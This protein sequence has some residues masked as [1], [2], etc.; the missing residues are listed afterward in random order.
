MQYRIYWTRLRYFNRPGASGEGEPSVYSYQITWSIDGRYIAFTDF[1]Y[2]QASKITDG[3]GL[4][5]FSVA[6]GGGEPEVT[7][8]RSFYCEAISRGIYSCQFHP[9]E[10]ILLFQDSNSTYI[11]TFKDSERAGPTPVHFPDASNSGW[12]SFEVSFTQCG[13]FIAVYHSGKPWP[14]LMPL[15]DV[16]RSGWTSSKP[17]RRLPEVIKILNTAA[18]DEKENMEDGEGDDND[19]DT[20]TTAEVEGQA[21]G[22]DGALVAPTGNGVTVL[23]PPSSSITSSAVVLSGDSS[24]GTMRRLNI[25][26]NEVEIKKKTDT[27]ET[28][29]SVL[30]L[31]QGIP[32]R[33]GFRLMW[34]HQV[35]MIIRHC[36]R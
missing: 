21:R 19:E 10:D 26:S 13:K 17:S 6:I 35:Q 31:P 29:T 11:W 25:I 9:S 28:R 5:I 7:F 22:S 4:A 12:A 16:L 8:L 32:T 24:P 20:T 23:G 3:A 33:G 27:E 36:T 14:E 1:D 15:G 34:R 30:R 2:F 18:P